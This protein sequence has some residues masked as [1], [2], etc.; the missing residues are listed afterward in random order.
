[1][2]I[3]FSNVYSDVS[4]YSLSEL[5]ECQVPIASRSD[6]LRQTVHIALSPTYSCPTAALSS[7]VFLCLAH[8]PATHQHIASDYV[9]SGM[10]KTLQD[11]ASMADDT[12]AGLSELVGLK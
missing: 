4:L 5:P 7:E 1:M 2:K 9:I 12:P 3:M 11:R 10:L 6:I 8:A